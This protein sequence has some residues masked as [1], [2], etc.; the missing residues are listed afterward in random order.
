M[1]CAGG[2]SSSDG[3][4]MALSAGTNAWFGTGANG[5]GQ[6]GLGDEVQRNTFTQLTGNWSQMFGGN[7]FTMALSAT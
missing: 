4:T 1:V 6:L 7:N 2:Q 3:H 5:N